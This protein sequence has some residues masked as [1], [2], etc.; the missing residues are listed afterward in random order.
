MKHTKQFRIVMGLI[1]GLAIIIANR[2]SAQ[3]PIT[4][5]GLETGAQN[6]TLTDSGGGNFSV[7]TPT[8]NSAPRAL[9][10]FSA[11]FSTVGEVVQLSGSVTLAGNF[12]NEQFRFGL[13]NNN[14]NALGTLSGGL[15]SGATSSGWLGYVIEPGNANGSGTTAVYGRNGSGANGWFST[16]GAAYSLANNADTGVGAAAN[17]V[18]S[19]NL[20]LT[21]LAANSVGVSYSFIETDGIGNL[22]C[23]GSVTDNGGLSSGMSSFN[24]AGFLLNANTGAATFNN[25][26]ISVP[27]PSTC[28]LGG[29][30]LASLVLVR[31]RRRQ[32]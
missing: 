31:A 1:A 28:I 23:V 29:L 32:A 3:T 26:E 15:W 6:A 21:L 25:V 16:S 8:G 22:S 14:G 2:A 4:G 24:T 17:G 19:F 13:F 27:E 5:W 7:T 9:L 10:P 18:Y 11:D 30:G 12:G 20:T